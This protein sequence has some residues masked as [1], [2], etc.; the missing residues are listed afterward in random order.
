LYRVD[1][2]P[3]LGKTRLNLQNNW[4]SS[5]LLW[6]KNSFINLGSY[7][8]TSYSH[9]LCHYCGFTLRGYA[10]VLVFLCVVEICHNFIEAA[11]LHTYIGRI[12]K[13]ILQS[14]TLPIT[15]MIW[16]NSLTQPHFAMQS[17]VLYSHIIGGTDFYSAYLIN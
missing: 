7:S 9:N 14:N 4:W 10:C 12:I 11:Q 17:V 1:N 6:T 16:I 8:I 2:E 15:D 5:E 13:C 3:D